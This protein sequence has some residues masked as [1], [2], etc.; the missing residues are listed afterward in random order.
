MSP[1]AGLTC[2]LCG[3]EHRPIRLEP[4]DRAL[5][6][7]CDSVL[8]CGGRAGSDTPFAFSIA[9]LA[10]AVPATL[11]P[12]VSAGLAGGERISLLFTGV[13]RLWVGGMQPLAVLVFLCGGLL[14]IAVLVSLAI[15]HA[16][17]WLGGKQADFRWLERAVGVFG[18][19]AIPEV[20]VL[21]VL[22]AIMKLRSVVDVTIGPGFWCY[23]AMVFSLL[24]AQRSAESNPTAPSTG[25]GEID[26]AVPP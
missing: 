5:C 18:H 20:Q 21:A 4:G 15:L 2:H 19:W 13:R 14:P 23:C 16:P 8:Q 11:L 22:V 26:A 12:F 9:G 17:S 3:Q 24:I 1:N 25:A 10:L 6:V 7:R